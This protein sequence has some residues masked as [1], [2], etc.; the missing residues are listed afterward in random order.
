[1]AEIKH[2][3]SIT[4]LRPRNS[5]EIWSLYIY[6]NNWNKLNN[7]NNKSG[8]ECLEFLGTHCSLGITTVLPLKHATQ[9]TRDSEHRRWF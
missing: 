1:M 6:T 4:R 7:W 2:L 3:G 9:R 8:S 5:L